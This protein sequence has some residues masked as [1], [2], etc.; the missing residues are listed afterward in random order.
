MGIYFYNASTCWTDL[1]SAIKSFTALMG[2]DVKRWVPCGYPSS[3]LTFHYSSSI[4]IWRYPSST[5]TF[6][7]SSSIIIWRY[8]SLSSYMSLSKLD[9]GILLSI[10]S[11]LD[12]IA[13]MLFIAYL[14]ELFIVQ[15][16]RWPVLL[17]NII[18]IM[19]II[20]HRAATTTITTVEVDASE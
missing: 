9:S 5:L 16:I 4:I 1:S 14:L 11:E 10:L 18:I 7:Y 20:V 3:T 19:I 8:P 17:I 6:H 13:A 12:C 15:R 2:R